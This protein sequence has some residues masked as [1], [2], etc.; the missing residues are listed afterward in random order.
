MGQNFLALAL[1]EVASKR[2]LKMAQT[3]RLAFWLTPPEAFYMPVV[4]KI[5]LLLLLKLLL[6]Y[7]F[8]CKNYSSNAALQL[9]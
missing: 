4:V 8:K 1:K 7:K 2:F 5:M 9:L 3:N 6:H